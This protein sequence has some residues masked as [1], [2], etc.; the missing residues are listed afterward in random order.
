[1]WKE[2]PPTTAA[3]RTLRASEGSTGVNG[4]QEMPRLIRGRFVPE[5]ERALLHDLEAA[6]RSDPWRARWILVPSRVLRRRLRRRLAERVPGAFNLHVLL[7]PELA[8]RRLADAAEPPR[9][10]AGAGGLLLLRGLAR[11][12]ADRP[13]SWFAEV[14]TRTGFLAS[15]A[16]TFQDL[17]EAAFDP[18]PAPG[19]R[20]VPPGGVHDDKLREVMALY[21]EWRVRLIGLGLETLPI[22]EERAAA[23]PAGS[24]GE[25]LWCY[26]F[27]DLTGTQRRL[28]ASAAA[29][30]SAA[31]YVPRPA[32][33]AAEYTL[34]TWE[35]LERR[36]APVI[37]LPD[38]P[39]VP[40]PSTGWFSAPGEK[41]EA[42]EVVRRV[43]ARLEAGARPERIGVLYRAADPYADPLR[44]AFARAGLPVEES[45][46]PPLADTR[47]GRGLRRFVQMVMNDLSRRDLLDFLDLAESV[48]D[49]AG[50]ASWERLTRAAGVSR[51]A[52][53]W[54]ERLRRL[55]AG[56]E[57]PA[58]ASADPDESPR[59]RRDRE[60][61][62]LDALEVR[63]AE[64]RPR[65]EGLKRSRRWAD[66]ARELREVRR[67]WFPEATE[68][69]GALDDLA[70]LDSC[71]EPCDLPGLLWLL[72]QVLTR[73]A[74]AVGDDRERIFV[75]NV[76][77][78]RGLD[79][80]HL[81][82]LG[83]TEKVF[84]RAVTQDPILLDAERRWLARRAEWL[85]ARRDAAAEE[86][87]LFRLAREMAPGQTWSWSRLDAATG[88]PRIASP[89]LLTMASEEAGQP[90]DFDL[91]AKG[92]E[93][94]PI[95]R[96]SEARRIGERRPES[97]V[98]GP[99]DRPGR[100]PGDSSTG[101]VDARCALD[102]NEFELMVLSAAVGARRLD[103]LSAW[104]AEA[105]FDRRVIAEEARHGP[106]LTAWDGRL[107][108]EAARA[109]VRRR[110]EI[111]GVPV[112]SATRL[113][114]WA[115]CPMRFFV[116]RLLGVQEL[117]DPEEL[118]RVSALDRGNLMHAVLREFFADETARRLD[119]SDA[120]ALRERLAGLVTG[121]LDDFERSGLTG[122]PLLWD[123]DRARI[124][125][126]LGEWLTFE[127]H[128]RDDRRPTSFEL[129]F[130]RSA[131]PRRAE[132][133]DS[134]ER[135]ARLDLPGGGE[136]LFGG[137]IDRIDWDAE[138]C[139]ARIVDYKS[140][141]VPGRKT[142]DLDGGRALQLPVYRLALEA[143]RPGASAADAEYLH[144][145]GEVT[146][147][148]LDDAT[149]HE[150]LDGLRRVVPVLA[151][152]IRDGAF[153]ARPDESGR[154]GCRCPH[155]SICGADRVHR[156]ERKRNDPAVAAL[157][158]LS[159]PAG[160]EAE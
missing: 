12:L 44:R 142:V 94:V 89:F 62:A 107:A 97:V 90:L 86:L 16:A 35:W 118:E 106:R 153:W 77:E 21:Q 113:E 8:E 134:T 110:L 37:D 73:P 40:P 81:F 6:M 33:D 135:P 159:G 2:S 4:R 99:G 96:L 122:Y 63:L 141:R 108:S 5:L 115:A 100:T 38:D 104:R 18:S 74:P 150:L 48:V 70:A 117:D 95:D 126:E 68:V 80:D 149:F 69:D 139:R 155:A 158:A 41:R 9:P 131:D 19:D 51:G 143:I 82:V 34:P 87:L 64:I 160:E 154:N 114:A 124:V 91:L 36:C 22:R 144:L 85:P 93:R 56:L 17:G 123:L 28:L 105:S 43:L 79:F 26:G 111:E 52:A 132:D 66:A 3:G 102:I 7:L 10:L 46:R 55:R 15:L 30:R 156:F 130:G 57:S 125:E 71:G 45:D 72:D 39:A 20:A 88:R 83:V 47:A 119:P 157:L 11:P 42:E 13:G 54:N 61:A 1:M 145:S 27:Y 112:W 29:G 116:E 25:E 84:P 59:P 14:A 152:G 129:R 23:L 147:R 75:G 32:R 98:P 138:R 65:V 92:E 128:R 49:A 101:R 127:L 120:G 53:S 50:V 76:M 136:V 148:P 67:R 137:Y 121:A 133:P 146:S 109:I 103:R 58:P 24:G 151:Q 78:A 140:G 31:F 60:L